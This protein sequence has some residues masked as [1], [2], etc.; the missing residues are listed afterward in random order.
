MCVYLYSVMMKNCNAEF[1]LIRTFKMFF[2]TVILC[3]IVFMIYC[4]V[5]RFIII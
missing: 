4:R 1:L 5:F 3:C 2:V